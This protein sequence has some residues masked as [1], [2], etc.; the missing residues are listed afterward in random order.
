MMTPNKSDQTKAAAAHQEMAAYAIMAAKNIGLDVPTSYRLA[1]ELNR[2][3]DAGKINPDFKKVLLKQ[4]Q[5][6]FAAN[7]AQAD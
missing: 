1:N 6:W 3:M 7:P 5:D 2:L 4:A